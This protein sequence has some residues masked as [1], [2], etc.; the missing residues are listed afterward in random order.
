MIDEKTSPFSIVSED[1]CSF[2]FLLSYDLDYQVE[3]F[4]N[5]VKEVEE[6]PRIELKNTYQTFALKSRVSHRKCFTNLN[7]VPVLTNVTP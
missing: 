4:E 2:T 1:I 7:I 6:G 3:A 5:W